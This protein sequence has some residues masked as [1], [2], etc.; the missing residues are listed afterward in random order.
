MSTQLSPREREEM[1]GLVEQGAARI[2]A[3]GRIAAR[4]IAVS[5]VAVLAVGVGLSFWLVPRAASPIS[6][7]RTS[8][9]AGIPECSRW[10]RMSTAA[11][12]APGGEAISRALAR[13]NLPTGIIVGPGITVQDSSVSGA[14]PMYDAVVRVCSRRMSHNELVGIG[15][16]VAAAAYADPSHPSLATLTIASWIPVDNDAIGQDPFNEPITTDFQSHDWSAGS[17]P[18][19]AWR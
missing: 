18:T 19:G 17:P 5:V 6:P 1:R 11:P 4:V 14:S 16:A 12:T 8:S 10:A 13:A 7:P 3:A 2:H 15:N 9:S